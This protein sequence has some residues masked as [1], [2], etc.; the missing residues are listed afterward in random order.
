[1][2]HPLIGHYFRRDPAGV[3]RCQHPGCASTEVYSRYGVPLPPW[4]AW[5]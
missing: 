4:E 2:D 3:W 1:M 5:T